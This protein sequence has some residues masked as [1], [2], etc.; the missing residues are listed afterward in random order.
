MKPFSRLLGAF[1][2]VM[3]GAISLSAIADPNCHGK[4]PNPIT[5]YC[6]SCSFPIGLAG[7]VKVT[8]GQ[9][10][11]TSSNTSGNPFCACTGS[12]AGWYADELGASAHGRCH[13]HAVLLRRHVA[14][15]AWISGSQ[16]LAMPRQTK[17]G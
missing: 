10:E 3:I 16:L 12:P 14:E 13:A 15:S 11:N 1:V 9:D 7:G 2:G 5:D 6:W 4:F 8:M 17:G